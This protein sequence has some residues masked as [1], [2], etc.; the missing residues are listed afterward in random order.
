MVEKISAVNCNVLTGLCT[1]MQAELC[2]QVTDVIVECII[3]FSCFIVI[4][5]YFL[6]TQLKLTVVM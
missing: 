1:F 5:I 6:K 2:N 3:R 4:I